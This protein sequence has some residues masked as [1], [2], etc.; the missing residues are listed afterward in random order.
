MSLLYA[1]RLLVAEV[2]EEI[3]ARIGNLADR[4]DPYF[5]HR[6][7]AAAAPTRPADDPTNKEK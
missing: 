2:L 3:S 5:D 7:P 4:V 6:A 1:V